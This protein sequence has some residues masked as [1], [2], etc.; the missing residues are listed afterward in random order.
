MTNLNARD[1]R[2]SIKWLTS[3]PSLMAELIMCL[4]RTRDHLAL[5]GWKRSSDFGELVRDLSNTLL[6]LSKLL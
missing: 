6:K 3:W 1:L 5:I 4:I 2:P